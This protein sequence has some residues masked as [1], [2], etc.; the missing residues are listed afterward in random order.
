MGFKVGKELFGSNFTKLVAFS[1]RNMRNSVENP[2]DNPNIF[3]FY[4]SDIDQD[5]TMKLLKSK[6]IGTF[7]MRRSSSMA[8]CYTLCVRASKQIVNVR[9]SKS[10]SG[11][12]YL[13]LEQSI[14]RKF[15]TLSDLF[16]DLFSI[17]TKSYQNIDAVVTRIQDEKTHGIFELKYPLRNDENESNL[18]EGS[19]NMMKELL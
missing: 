7:L 9:I 5:Q 12:Y 17:E 4:Y 15:P 11:E 18:N 19:F 6:P 10:N 8:S 14:G 1:C 13:D 2:N 16:L 3:K